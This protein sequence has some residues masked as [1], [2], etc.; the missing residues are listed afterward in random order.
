MDTTGNGV[1]PAAPNES[2]ELDNTETQATESNEQKLTAR[3]LKMLEMNQRIREERAVDAGEP[4]I[5]EPPADQ[6]PATPATPAV[7]AAKPDGGPEIFEKDGKQF[8]RLKAYGQ[9]EEVPLD[10]ALR[11]AQKDVAAEKKLKEAIERERRAAAAEQLAAQRLQSVKPVGTLPPEVQA[12]PSADLL[13]EVKETLKQHYE[14]DVEGAAERLAKVLAGRQQTTPISPEQI[15]A[16]VRADL[17]RDAAVQRKAKEEADQLSAFEVFEEK[18]GDIVQN[19]R[20]FAYA[21]AEVSLLMQQ[22]PSLSIEQAFIK[23][24]ET[25]RAMTQP[26]VTPPDPRLQAKRS[27]PKPINASRIPSV[28]TQ[29]EPPPKPI[30]HADVIA[31][32]RATRGQAPR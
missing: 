15:A 23:A 30:T 5:E 12:G 27:A 24:G 16:Q 22:D 19:P 14:G 1:T 17:Q 31:R 8:V 21:D 6:T 25:V 18:F 7:T 26:A 10:V 20:L 29:I 9:V 2:S 3:E 4:A 11:R 13:N 28:S 32:M